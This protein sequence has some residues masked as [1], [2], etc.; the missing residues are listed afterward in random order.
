[1]L[2]PPRMNPTCS[3]ELPAH[4]LAR[5]AQ[6]ARLLHLSLTEPIAGI[7]ALA[8]ALRLALEAAMDADSA[9]DHAAAESALQ[10]ALADLRAARIAVTAEI[11]AVE[12]EGILG[13]AQLP[14]LS[15]WLAPI[16]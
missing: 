13:P 14:A 8:R 10:L 1:M 15:A 7:D 5:L 2:D 12:V 16:P 4:E 9:E 11:S 6:G 3:P